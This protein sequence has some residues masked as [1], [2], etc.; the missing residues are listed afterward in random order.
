[1]DPTNF[2]NGP[3]NEV[4]DFSPLTS[5]CS[6]LLRPLLRADPWKEGQDE[7]DASGHNLDHGGGGAGN[8]PKVIT[9]TNTTF[10]MIIGQVLRQGVLRRE[11]GGGKRSLSSPLLPLLHMQPTPGLNKVHKLVFV[12]TVPVSA[13]LVFG[14]FI[15]HIAV[16]VTDL[17][18][19]SSVGFATKGKG[20]GTLDNLT[21]PR[22]HA[23]RFLSKL[24]K[25][26][27]MNPPQLKAPIL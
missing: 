8:L 20:E 15:K 10:I 14:A 23:H 21:F 27:F 25:G 6:D 1:M 18:T 26:I 22:T 12:F 24:C 2:A 11:D 16:C 13:L 3:D 9:G 19:R 7:V 5:I 4:A 17:T